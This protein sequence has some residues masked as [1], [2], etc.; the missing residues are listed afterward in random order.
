MKNQI[1]E[2]IF[3]NIDQREILYKE[4][5]STLESLITFTSCGK[6]HTEHGMDS[7]WCPKESDVT[8]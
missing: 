8:K 1:K 5:T 6:R 7:P 4:E 2:G 3:Q